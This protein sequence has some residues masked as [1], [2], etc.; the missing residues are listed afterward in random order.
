MLHYGFSN[1]VIGFIIWFPVVYVGMALVEYVAHRWFMHKK[2]FLTKREFENHTVQHHGHRL[3]EP[4][5]PY[6]DLPVRYHLIFGIPGWGG[7]LIGFLSGGPY[8]L[9]GLIA[10]LTMFFFHSYFY[11]KVH[12]AQHD[13]EEN[14]TQR[15]PW[16]AELKR[17]HLDHHIRPSRNFA[18]VFL[19]TDKLFGT[20]WRSVDV[21]NISAAQAAIS[22]AKIS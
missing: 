11:S 2:N 20:H 19:W 18:V 15:L 8:A 17:H 7:F 21:P 12:R 6:I 3:M 14:W 1:I 4:M 9:G 16:F 5:F 10:T 13:L 22:E